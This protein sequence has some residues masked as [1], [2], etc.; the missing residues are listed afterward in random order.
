MPPVMAAVEEQC[1]YIRMYLRRVLEVNTSPSSWH[2]CRAWPWRRTSR[3]PLS[4]RHSLDR[5]SF[6]RL[7]AC[8]GAL[9]R[10]ISVCRCAWRGIF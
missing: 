4:H 7:A 10:A 5:G 6:V 2:A 8:F 9:T 1:T 3:E